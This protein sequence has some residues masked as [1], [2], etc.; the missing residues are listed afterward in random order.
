MI[1]PLAIPSSTCAAAPRFSLLSLTGAA[2][3][4]TRDNPVIS[5]ILQNQM[6][7]SGQ[8]QR[9]HRHWAQRKITSKWF[10]VK[11]MTDVSPFFDYPSNFE[12]PT[13]TQS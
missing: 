4:P 13:H 1:L 3:A 11:F 8:G 12:G 9:N 6:T 2:N 10:W 7:P 5:P